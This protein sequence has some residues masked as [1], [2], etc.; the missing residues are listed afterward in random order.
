MQKTT[1][2]PFPL[3][4]KWARRIQKKKGYKENLIKLQAGNLG[5]P[6]IP[7]ALRTASD[8][9]AK[10]QRRRADDAKMAADRE[11]EER[12]ALLDRLREG[13][14]AEVK[15]KGNIFRKDDW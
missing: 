4:D 14:V 7:V 9:G 12:D 10:A 5:N 2:H 8:A 13:S 15:T 1:N 11:K 6:L 3:S